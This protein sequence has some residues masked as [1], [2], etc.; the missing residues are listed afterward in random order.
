MNRQLAA[1]VVA[2]F[3]TERTDVT[4]DRFAGF[5][6]RQWMRSE[7]WLHSSGLALYFLDRAR[8]LEIVDVIPVRILN[9]LERNLADNRVR[10]EALFQEFVKINM[11]FQRAQLSYANLRGFTLIPSSCSNPAYRYQHGL[12]FLVSRHDAERCRQAVERQGYQLTGI[13]SKKWE[14]RSG[15]AEIPTT[16]DLYETR[17]LPN[18][19]VH[20]VSDTEPGDTGHHDGRLARMQLQVFNGVEFPALSE[21]DKLLA[22]ALHIFK[23]LQKE[24]TRAAWILE[25]ASAIDSRRN[26]DS[27][28][29][30]IVAAIDANPEIRIA[31]GVS[32][33]IAKRTFGADL[34]KRF[35]SATVDEIPERIRLWVDRYE[36]ELVLVEHPGSK[37]YLLL[38]DILRENDPYWR[39][40][41]RNKLWSLAL[42]AKLRPAVD[43]KNIGL[44]TNFLFA[45]LGFLGKRLRFHVVESLRYRVEAARWKRLVSASRA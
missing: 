28:W 18:L 10:A 45:H 16:H 12:D 3:R 41:R 42:P 9:E 37:L 4:R 7:S 33:L 26:D 31:V 6:E 24:W 11:E 34:P 19:K 8:Q 15:S 22:Q 43:G 39:S 40:Q 17:M 25:Y 30:E 5:D 27:F 13:S 38:R 1:S 29:Q 14:F 36:D 2:S 21:R 35:L 20:F 44:R 32:S 23:H